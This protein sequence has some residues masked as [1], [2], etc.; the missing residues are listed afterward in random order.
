M[1]DSTLNQINLAVSGNPAGLTW[2]GNVSS[3]WDVFNVPNTTWNNGSSADIFY[4]LDTVSF[5]DSGSGANPTINVSDAT[6]GYVQPGS[7]IV[8][9]GKNYT[10]NGSSK[11]TGAT[12][13]TKQGTG[14]LILNNQG[15]D[16]SGPIQIDN[17]VLQIG[18]G[19]TPS[20]SIGTG[21]I[22]NNAQLVF[23]QIENHTVSQA[24][25]GSGSVEQR[26]SSSVLTLSGGNDYDGATLVTAGFLQAGNSACAGQHG[27]R[28]DYLQRGHPGHQQPES[29]Q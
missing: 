9:A 13:L 11:I 27:G 14:T 5:T 26:G 19:S 3:N 8:S 29:G 22:T 24:I 10:F 25:H 20:T 7:I 16:F 1:D 15:N 12:G 23:N 17:G 21:T 28:H 4:N 2:V 18:D 6:L